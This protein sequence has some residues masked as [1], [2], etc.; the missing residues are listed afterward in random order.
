VS[1]VSGDEDKALSQNVTIQRHILILLN[2]I[3]MLIAVSKT[4]FISMC[5]PLVAIRLGTSAQ[6]VPSDLLSCHAGGSQEVARW[7]WRRK[8]RMLEEIGHDR[9]NKRSRQIEIR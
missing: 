1:V 7:E 2:L 5:T 9:Q 3:Y 8:E 4:V 6:L